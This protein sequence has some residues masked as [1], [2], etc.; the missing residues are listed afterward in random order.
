MYLPEEL[1]RICRSDSLLTPETSHGGD[2]HSGSAGARL[3]KDGGR[4]GNGVSE[5]VQRGWK[6]V[7]AR[8]AA[9]ESLS[10]V[11][12]VS[13]F[14]L[15]EFGCCPPLLCPPLLCPPLLRLSSSR[16]FPLSLFPSPSPPDT[17]PLT[18]TLSL[19]PFV[20]WCSFLL[21]VI[22]S[23]V[24]RVRVCLKAAQAS[25]EPRLPGPQMSI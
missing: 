4:L 7:L 13:C 15:S 24:G 18:H 17:H 16:L 14:P 1:D 11:C 5:C 21:P 8:K 23:K 2:T 25:R 12:V 3:L 9:P 22:K 10:A 20:K 6:T 19:Y